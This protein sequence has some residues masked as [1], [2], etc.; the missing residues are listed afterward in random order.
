M[1]A[2]EVGEQLGVRYVMVG[3]VRKSRDTVRITAELVRAADGKQLWS[4]K[5]DLQ[6]EYIFD[7]QEEMARQIA[8]TI[9]PE[10]SK[11]EQQLAARKAPESLDAW[12]WRARKCDK[13]ASNPARTRLR[14]TGHRSADQ[15]N[16][17]SSFHAAQYG[18]GQLSRLEARIQINLQIPLILCRV[19]DARRFRGR[20]SYEISEKTLDQ[21]SEIPATR[22]PSTN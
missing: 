17:I 21:T 16:E 1:D 18:S 9:E 15:R 10:L 8:A 19:D 13:P 14:R 5:Y 3:S 22:S 20:L 12:D 6:L 7:I 11:V 4:D 2:R